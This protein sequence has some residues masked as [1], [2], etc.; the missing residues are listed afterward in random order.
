MAAKDRRG[1][2]IQ[3]SVLNG[4][5]FVEI[6]AADQKTL[7]V[8]FLNNKVALVGTVTKARITGGETIPEVPV[9]PI[10][11]AAD[12]STD[13]DGNPLLT[14]R[15]DAP[16]DFSTYTLSLTTNLLD[17]VFASAKF[18]FKALC[19]STLDCETPPPECPPPAGDLPP[20]D[21]LAKD[22][23]SFCKALS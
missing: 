23:E 17:P 8:H 4:I 6:A 18:S 2:V 19:P 5:D 7:R 11:D 3:S 21:Y 14:L 20:I 9:H 15:V 22:F 10:D 12:W 16:G 1:E 13:S